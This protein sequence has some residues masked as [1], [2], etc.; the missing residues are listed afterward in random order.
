[1]SIYVV[2]LEQPDKKAW[3][4]LKEKWPK[5]QHYILDGRVAFVAPARQHASEV[6]LTEDISEAL[7]MGTDTQ[8]WGIVAEINRKAIDGWHDQRLWEWVD[9]VPA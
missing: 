1:M 9:K 5:R 8:R 6:F 2:I 3:A 7:G 4:V